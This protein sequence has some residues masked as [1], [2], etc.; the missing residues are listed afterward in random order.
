MLPFI[1]KSRIK[2]PLFNNKKTKEEEKMKGLMK[3]VVFVAIAILLQ[4]VSGFG[5]S[6][7]VR[8]GMRLLVVRGQDGIPYYTLQRLEPKAGQFFPE[9]RSCYG[10][11]FMDPTVRDDDGNGFP[12]NPLWLPIPGG[13]GVGSDPFPIAVVTKENEVREIFFDVM[14]ADGNIYRTAFRPNCEKPFLEG[15]LN[16]PVLGLGDA[17]KDGWPGNTEDANP[18]VRVVGSTQELLTQ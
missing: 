13:L 14:G 9:E 16:S 2:S 10:N 4:P 1:Q 3:L 18:W 6:A 11:P 15:V 8:S 5:A 12:E 17:D 7:L